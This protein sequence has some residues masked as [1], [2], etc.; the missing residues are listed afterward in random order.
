MGNRFG[1][2]RLTSFARLDVNI[3]R[4]AIR[5]RWGSFSMSRQRFMAIVVMVCGLNSVTVGEDKSHPFEMRPQPWE[6][7]A[8]PVLS[9]R[10]TKQTR[11]K[12]VCYSPHVIHHDGLFRMWYCFVVLIR[13]PYHQHIMAILE[14]IA[15]RAS[16]GKVSHDQ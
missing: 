16:F 13:T 15:R 8:E 10:M 7:R 3:P 6:R 9:A 2:S 4:G 11:C 5:E 1:V 14:T 12:V